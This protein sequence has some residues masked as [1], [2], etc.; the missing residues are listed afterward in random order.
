M[1]RGSRSRP[2]PKPRRTRPRP[3]HVDPRGL[4][5]A[6]H[7]CPHVALASTDLEPQIDLRTHR[8]GTR[9][10]QEGSGQADVVEIE[11]QRAV[12]VH[13]VGAARA[14]VALVAAPLA[15]GV[16]AQRLEEL[17]DRGGLRQVG[18]GAQAQGALGG[19]GVQVGSD[20]HDARTR[21]G[22]GAH[23]LQ[24]LEPVAALHDHVADHQVD[25]VVDVDQRHRGG[26]V[27]RVE[28]LVAERLEQHAQEPAVDIGVIDDERRSQS[29]HAALPPAGFCLWPVAAGNATGLVA[30]Q[31]PASRP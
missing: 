11:H 28:D 14:A 2:R 7:A 13:Q 15:P 17:A 22:P 25:V 21:L 27:G 16:P 31:C 6:H 30:S 4:L 19:V 3:G 23:V 20:H 26:G 18:G 9:R 10:L 5:H 8:K 1:A 12:A 24:H 29:P